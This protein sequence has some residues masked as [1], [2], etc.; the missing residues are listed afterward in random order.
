M[1]R[2]DRTHARGLIYDALRDLKQFDGANTLI[3]SHIAR[4]IIFA[5]RLEGFGGAFLPKGCGWHAGYPKG[6]HS[7]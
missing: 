1:S 5:I 7:V 4:P 2:A 6:R 3:G